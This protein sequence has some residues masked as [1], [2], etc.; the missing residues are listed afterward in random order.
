MMKIFFMTCFGALALSGLHASNV[1][2]QNTTE[3]GCSPVSSISAISLTGPS[4][5]SNATYQGFIYNPTPLSYRR[6]SYRRTAT[7]QSIVS[8]HRKELWEYSKG[9]PRKQ[10]H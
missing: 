9:D 2:G 1:L 3:Y 8:G 7:N 4:I 6:F 5:A 10:Q